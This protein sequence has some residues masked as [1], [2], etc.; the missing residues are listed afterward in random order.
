MNKSEFNDFSLL[1]LENDELRRRLKLIKRNAELARENVYFIFR[2]LECL[3]SSSRV[4]NESV[5]VSK[6]DQLKIL[7]YIDNIIKTN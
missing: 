2:E 7:N 5:T 6:E 1:Q 3:F 4:N